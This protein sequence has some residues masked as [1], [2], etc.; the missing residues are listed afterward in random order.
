MIESL[1]PCNPTLESHLTLTA[2]SAVGGAMAKPSLLPHDPDVAEVMDDTLECC[3]QPP[4]L[5]ETVGI[6][7]FEDTRHE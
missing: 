7:E 3:D 1:L 6:R 5:R 4:K 2:L